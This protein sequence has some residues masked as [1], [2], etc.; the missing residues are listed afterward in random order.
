MNTVRVRLFF[1]AFLML[2]A[3]GLLAEASP[4]L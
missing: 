4:P 3:V 2:L 1:A